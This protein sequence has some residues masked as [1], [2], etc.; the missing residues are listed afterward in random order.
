MKRIR[1]SK[2]MDEYTDTEVF[3]TEGSTVDPEA[4]KERVLAQTVPGK[5]RRVPPKKAILLAAALA[6]GCLLS[7]AA[8]LPMKVYQFVS[9]ASTVVET[10][11]AEGEYYFDIS[12]NMEPSPV[13]LEDG[14][15]WIVL[16]NDRADVTDLIDADTPYIMEGRDPE[17]GIKAYLAVGGTPE[18]YGWTMWREIPPGGYTSASWNN[19]TAYCEVDGKLVEYQDWLA[20]ES[21]TIDDPV[22]SDL[23]VPKITYVNKPWYENVKKVQLGLFEN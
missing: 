8:G 4:V 21:L 23:E 10:A 12:W 2:L 18:D 22:P 17:T 7:I 9:D 5:R 15:L 11:G 1:I 20:S 14:R 19:Q 16:Y 6:V 13:V 3:P